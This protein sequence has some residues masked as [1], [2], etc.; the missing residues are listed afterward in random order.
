MPAEKLQTFKTGK[1]LSLIGLAKTWQDR[2]RK[3]PGDASKCKERM[4]WDESKTS[5]QGFGAAIA[6]MEQ[7][8][9]HAKQWDTCQDELVC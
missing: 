2:E 1:K 9:T 8:R 7:E 6:Y 4:R 5:W 3:E